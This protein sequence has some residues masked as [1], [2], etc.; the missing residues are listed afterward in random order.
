MLLDG[1]IHER[2][3]DCGNGFGWSVIRWMHGSF[4]GDCYEIAV[5]KNGK[6]TYE[7]PIT[8]DVIRGDWKRIEELKNQVRELKRGELS[9]EKKN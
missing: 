8:N 5:L 9:D 4:Y 3:T 6:I 2:V 7:T 1:K